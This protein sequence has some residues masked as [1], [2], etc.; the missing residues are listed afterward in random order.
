MLN[1]G[2][3]ASQACTPATQGKLHKD[4][5]HELSFN[6]G[7][8]RQQPQNPPAQHPQAWSSAPPWRRWWVP[9][10]SSSRPFRMGLS[11]PMQST[12]APGAG[13]GMG[14]AA[15]CDTS[16]VSTVVEACRSAECAV[17]D[18]AETS[19]ICFFALLSS[20]P[21]A[22]SLGGFCGASAMNAPSSCSHPQ[23]YSCE[24]VL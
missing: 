17:P 2:I 16:N 5:A 24:A 10:P 6:A 11:T 4:A 21:G 22:G 7:V 12:G 23:P 15:V 8:I 3:Y 14:D 20:D 9:L 19:G 18:P 13:A 1:D